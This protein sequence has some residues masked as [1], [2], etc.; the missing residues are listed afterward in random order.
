MAT[1]EEAIKRLDDAVKKILHHDKWKWFYKVLR[2]FDGIWAGLV[3]LVI[4]LP[5]IWKDRQF[6][7]AYLYTVLRH[8]LRLMEKFFDS[9]NTWS[10]GAKRHVKDIR[11][12]RILCDRLIEDWYPSFNKHDWKHNARQNKQDREYL[13]DLMKRNVDKWWD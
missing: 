10:V 3:N 12:A 13:F 5:I 8:K 6:D 7:H 2:F 9:N 1:Q 11:I 4:W